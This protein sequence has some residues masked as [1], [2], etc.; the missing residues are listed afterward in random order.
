VQ[1]LEGGREARQEPVQMPRCDRMVWAAQDRD[2][3]VAMDRQW[4]WGL[5][6]VGWEAKAT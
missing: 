1:E 6:D 4:I 2:K 3:V 5:L